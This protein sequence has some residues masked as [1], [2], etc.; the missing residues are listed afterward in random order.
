M[1]QNGKGGK[2]TNK[3]KDWLSRTM[4]G[5]IEHE[6]ATVVPTEA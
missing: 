1:G 5:E 3:I 4:Y 2:I 6:W